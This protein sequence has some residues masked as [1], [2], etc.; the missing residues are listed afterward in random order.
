MLFNLLKGIEYNSQTH[1]LIKNNKITKQNEASLYSKLTGHEK[2][3]FCI[4][5]PF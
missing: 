5:L 2:Y 4:S 3:S 1:W